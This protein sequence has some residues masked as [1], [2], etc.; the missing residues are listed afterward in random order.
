MDL[1]RIIH[2]LHVEKQKLDHAITFLEELQRTE[3][4]EIT[5][6]R[7]GRKAMNPA[8]RKQ[9]SDRMKKYWADRRAAVSA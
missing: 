9:V 8:A 7:R 5:E 4:K 2:E 3:N 1:Y 6:K